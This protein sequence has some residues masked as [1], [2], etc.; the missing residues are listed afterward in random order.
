M[1]RSEARR[2]LLRARSA[3]TEGEKQQAL[4]QIN[5]L[6][7]FLDKIAS[8][9]IASVNQIVDSASDRPPATLPLL[10]GDFE[11]PLETYWRLESVSQ[12]SDS[13]EQ[14]LGGSPPLAVVSDEAKSGN[15]CLAIHRTESERPTGNWA[16]SQAIPATTGQD[17]RVTVRVQSKDAVWQTAQ[18]VV[19]HAGAELVRLELAGERDTWTR[20]AGEFSIPRTDTSIDP[21]E[22]RVE[23]AD[24]EFGSVLLDEIKVTRIE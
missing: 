4:D 9:P 23:I 14:I 19:R 2:L 20:R 15:S 17:Y 10:G 13:G 7:T 21:L 22:I 6:K 1:S 18:L 16:L 3:A 24:P 11:L 12:S 8:L 5:A